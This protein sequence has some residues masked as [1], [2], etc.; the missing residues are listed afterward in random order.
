M[1]LLSTSRCV[2]SALTRVS[3]GSRCV[4]DRFNAHRHTF[5]GPLESTGRRFD[6]FGADL[7]T[8]KAR[9]NRVKAHR[10]RF[11]PR[12]HKFEARRG[13]FNA[14]PYT[15]KAGPNKFEARLSRFE[16]H[17]N[18]L[19]ARHYAFDERLDRVSGCLERGQTHRRLP[20]TSATAENSNALDPGSGMVTIPRVA[21]FV[22]RIVQSSEES[23]IV[24][25]SVVL[26][27]RWR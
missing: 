12:L 21:A 3:T 8:F 20:R 27:P 9:L 7:H 13:S 1:E 17:P 16:T 15:L 19:K 2:C 10:D 26:L 14:R 18:R 22:R 6:W 25:V 23:L 4:S 11:K 5:D 24:R